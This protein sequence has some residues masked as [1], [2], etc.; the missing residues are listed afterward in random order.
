MCLACWLPSWECSITTKWNTK[1][2]RPGQHFRRPN[3]T[4]S[5]PPP[6]CG[7]MLA[8]PKTPGTSGCRP[9]LTSC[10][11]PTTMALSPTPTTNSS[12][13]TQTDTRATL[14]P[15]TSPTIKG[16][17]A[18]Q[19]TKAN[20]EQ[21]D[22]HLQYSFRFSS[23]RLLHLKTHTEVD[24]KGQYIYCFLLLLKITSRTITSKSKNVL[25]TLSPALIL[26]QP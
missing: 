1:K 8:W 9:S 24:S 22:F 6:S 13:R 5:P 23:F 21:H 26:K 15:P 18:Q 19:G 12:L 11:R 25:G 16:R 4:S 17:S 20:K 10:H 2:I 7:I 3:Q 14:Q